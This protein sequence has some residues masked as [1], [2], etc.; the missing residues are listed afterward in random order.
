LA[1]K[2]SNAELITFYDFSGGLNLTRPGESIA[3]NELQEAVNFE[4]DPDTGA[5]RVRGGLS[6]VHMFDGPVTDILNTANGNAV[7]VRAGGR[8]YALN[9]ASHDAEDLGPVGGG[10]PGVSALW[11]ETGVVLAFG[12]H[13]Y[14]YDPS[15]AAELTRVDSEGAPENAEIL[16][17]RAGRVCVGR[18]GDDKLRISSLGDASGWTDD[19]ED[20]STSKEIDIGYKDGCDIRAIAQTVGGDI[21]VFKCPEG[22][23]ERGRIYRL[24]GDYP[25][26]SVTPY[27]E[28]SSA[29]NAQSAAIVGNDVMFLTRGGLA[30]ISA[31]TEYGDFKIGWAGAKVNPRMKGSLTPA[32]SLRNIPEAARLWVLNGADADETVWVYCYGIGDA[33]AWTTYRFPGPV[34]AV[35]SSQGK[36]LAAIGN[37]VYRMDDITEDDY[38]NKIDGKLVPR[39]ITRRNQVLLKGIFAKFDSSAT[40]EVHLR[41]EEMDFVIKYDD[42][43]DIAFLD[44]DIAYL[45]DEPLVPPPRS[46]EARRRC[47]IRRWRITPEITVVNGAFRMTLL[48]LEIAEV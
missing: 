33:G 29:W 3:D 47:D 2:H 15:G 22:Q 37:G 40:S 28:G 46:A 36:I 41:V 9:L 25:G 18:A 45:D 24:Q 11:G 13:L 26:W 42:D 48:Q 34:S 20:D 17:V 27:S 21:L 35:N 8:L 14:I 39:T 1:N 6:L 23:P 44:D 5:L 19:S 30:N 31:V 16:Y 32:S 38:G 12:G 7:L 43:G 10:K 4:Y